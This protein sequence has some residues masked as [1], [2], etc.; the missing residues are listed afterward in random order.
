MDKF[1][2]ALNYV[3]TDIV[4]QWDSS[5]LNDGKAILT[6]LKSAGDLNGTAFE[7]ALATLGE[8]NVGTSGND[9]ISGTEENDTLYGLAGN[10]MLSGK[11]GDDTLIGGAG[12]DHL[13]G[14]NGSDTYTFAAGFG[15]DTI[16]NTHTDSS[17]DTILFGEGLSP[18]NAVVSREGYDL[19]ISFGDNDSLRIYSYFDE[20]GQSSAVINTIKFSDTNE[21]TWQFADIAAMTGVADGSDNFYI[22][23]DNADTYDG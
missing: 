16:D 9:I 12:N 11:D 10:D 15:H 13:I 23:T 20:R 14:G 17:S 6:A 21:T 22:G 7:I 19:I 5:F 1:V 18:E 8:Q 2:K 4:T 3:T